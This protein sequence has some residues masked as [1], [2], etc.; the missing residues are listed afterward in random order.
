MSRVICAILK[1]VEG[2]L[3]LLLGLLLLVVTSASDGLLPLIPVCDSWHEL[4]M[5][6]IVKGEVRFLLVVGVAPRVGVR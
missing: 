2:D 6:S 4:T 3:F 1:F 5:L